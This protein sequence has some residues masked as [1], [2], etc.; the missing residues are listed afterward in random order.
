M[1]YSIVET[2]TFMCTYLFSEYE[3]EVSLC[4]VSEVLILL[5]FQINSWC[6]ERPRNA[7]FARSRIFASSGML[8]CVGDCLL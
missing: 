2:L 7:I 3:L 8:I 1:V 4:I 6:R 5:W